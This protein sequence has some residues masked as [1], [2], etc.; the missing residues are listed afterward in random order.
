MC[1]LISYQCLCTYSSF[2]TQYQSIHSP[3]GPWNPGD[4]VAP[5]PPG[6]PGMEAPGAP[7][8]PWGPGL[9]GGPWGPGIPGATKAGKET[10]A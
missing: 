7:T 1:I 9:P 8:G 6:E 10:L 5:G 2:F 4:P 3:G